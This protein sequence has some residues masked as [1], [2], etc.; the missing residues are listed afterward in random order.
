MIN[1]T[2][3]RILYV[4]LA[5]AIGF[6]GY[7]A[8][9]LSERT[10]TNAGSYVKEALKLKKLSDIIDSEYYFK[11]S[12][13]KEEAFDRAMMGYVNQL[14]DP[15]SGYIAGADLQSFTEEVEGNYVGI[16][17]EITVDEN[18]FITVINSFDGSAAQN[19]GI[20]T[21]DKLIKVS[22]EPV[23]GDQL[24]EV[25]D[26]IRGLPGETVD[27]EI[28]TAEGEVKPL[29]LTRSE[30]SVE[31]VRVKMLTDSIGYVRISSFDIG[32]DREFLE[33]MKFVVPSVEL[34]PLTSDWYKI[35]LK[36]MQ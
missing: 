8:G 9:I 36:Q 21:G 19:A 33:K 12:I 27:I 4:V 6:V 32:T 29:T 1:N 20:K 23:N 2:I 13:N 14:G 3:K 24:D 35:L 10:G 15:F 7:F 5:V 16:G 30:V 28:M 11:D 18:N 34:K 25:V 31:T 22:G 17:V 26:K